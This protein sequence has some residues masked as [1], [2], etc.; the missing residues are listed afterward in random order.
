MA[1][2]VKQM[3]VTAPYPCKSR[4]GERFQLVLLKKGTTLV[5]ERE[6]TEFPV[7]HWYP[8]FLY[9]W[10]SGTPFWT[11]ASS[12]QDSGNHPI[13]ERPIARYIY[14]VKEDIELILWTDE[15][16]A[17]ELTRLYPPYIRPP[18]D[19]FDVNDYAMAAFGCQVL[20][21]NGFISIN[22]DGK[23][24]NC[25]L[26]GDGSKWLRLTTFMRFGDPQP[27]PE[28]KDT[29]KPDAK[30]HW[31]PNI[32]GIVYY[33][34]KQV[35]TLRAELKSGN[36][37]KQVAVA[38]SKLEQAVVDAKLQLQMNTD[39]IAQ[40]MAEGDSLKRKADDLRQQLNSTTKQLV[41]LRSTLK[42]FQKQKPILAKALT[43]ALEELNK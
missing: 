19:E 34:E 39:G 13:I 4:F 20:G 41:E 16:I 1:V 8:H 32:A 7:G 42:R 10:Y 24:D 31:D 29:T 12:N 11:C 23:I 28:Y 35:A 2:D 9:N 27:H 6:E 43:A 36:F 40:I 15:D 30:G 5:H 37:A 3:C 33:D 18:Q 21:Y 38:G 22:K 14:T 26:A 17:A 25:I